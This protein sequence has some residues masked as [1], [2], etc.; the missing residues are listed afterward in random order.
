MGKSYK[1]N[2]EYARKWANQRNKFKKNTF[3][4]KSGKKNQLNNVDEV[5]TKYNSYTEE[6]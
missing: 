6:V 5:E 2:N 1:G 4:N 3:K